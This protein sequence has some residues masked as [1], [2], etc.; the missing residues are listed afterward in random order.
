ME[1]FLKHAVWP[2]LYL[3]IGV[4]TDRVKP[5]SPR[6]DVNEIERHSVDWQNTLGD[7][8]LNAK[9]DLFGVR[10]EQHR[11]SALEGGVDEQVG[12]GSLSGCVQV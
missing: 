2:P 5:T 8:A 4:K 7:S 6:S 10:F 9:E 11:A 1:V 12:Q 3:T